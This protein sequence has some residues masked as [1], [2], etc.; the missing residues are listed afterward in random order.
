MLGGD[1]RSDVSGAKSEGSMG[2]EDF[3]IVKVDAEGN[4]EWDRTYG[5]EFIDYLFTVLSLEDGG[6]LLAG[7]SFGDITDPLSGKQTSGSFA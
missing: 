4:K 3:W 5:S 7:R 2:A 6:F 1:S